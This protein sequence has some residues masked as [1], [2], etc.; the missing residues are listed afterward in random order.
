MSR[1]RVV[2]DGTDR[3]VENA[4]VRVRKPGELDNPPDYDPAAAG[5]M[6]ARAGAEPKLSSCL[7][8]GSTGESGPIG[9]S[10]GGSPAVRMAATGPVHIGR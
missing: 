5:K 3:L 1:G 10:F 2:V 9:L 4:V 7:A 6:S 8:T